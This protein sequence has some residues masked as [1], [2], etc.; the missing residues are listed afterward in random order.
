MSAGLPQ[1]LTLD[2]LRALL[3]RGV[4]K[5]TVTEEA[6]MVLRK[7]VMDARRI[8][9]PPPASVSAKPAANETRP[10]QPTP[11]QTPPDSVDEASFGNELR[12]ILNGVQPHRTEED[13]PVPRHISFDLEGET[14]EEKLSS[15]REL[16]VNWPP[17]R[18]MDSLRETPVFS[19]GNPKADI[20]MVTDAPGLYEEKQGVPLAGPSGQ[21]LD[22]MLKAMGLSR[23]DIYLTHLVKYRPAL[24]PAAYQQPPAYRPGDRN[25]P[26]HSPGGNYAGA[27]ESS[28]GPGSNL[29][30]RHP[31][32]RR[33][34]S[35]RPE[36]H[37]PHSFQHA[38]A[39]Y[40]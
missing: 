27:P 7:W 13:A 37:L 32:V 15:L 28:G 8:S 1:H 9:G 39:R 10:K 21:K 17:L 40:L 20:M 23:S 22:A 26:A 34:A 29:R 6:R 4:E 36:R 14:E 30:P 31:P 18:N 38:R 11:E 16:V 24:P 33:D 12:D 19:S 2:Y 3:S 35:F 5:T 25:F